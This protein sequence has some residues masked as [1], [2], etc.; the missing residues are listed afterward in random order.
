MGPGI[1]QLTFRLP[2]ACAVMKA[3]L[4]SLGADLGPCSYGINSC[5][6][7][8]VCPLRAGDRHPPAA[9]ETED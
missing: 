4:K 6:T 3:Q 9:L 1:E 8:C 2:D 7:C 5:I